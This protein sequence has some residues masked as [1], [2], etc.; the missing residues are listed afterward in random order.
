MAIVK[1]CPKCQL[2]M[3]LKEETIEYPDENTMRAV[4]PHCKETV[5]FKLVTQGSNA[6][7][8]KMGH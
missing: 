1:T 4:C 7:G 5:R 8:P 3:W 2:L 6:A